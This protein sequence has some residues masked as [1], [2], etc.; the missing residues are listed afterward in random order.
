MYSS[1]DL[2]FRA[3]QHFQTFDGSFNLMDNIPLH[4]L[5]YILLIRS[6]ISSTNQAFKYTRTRR[7]NASRSSLRHNC[8]R[9]LSLFL[10]L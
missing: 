5:L 2:Y 8:E 10:F 9:Q 3:P 6:K 1:R 7:N 4:F